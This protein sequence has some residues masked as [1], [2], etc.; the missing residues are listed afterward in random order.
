LVLRTTSHVK[1]IQS[2]TDDAKH[3]CTST[4]GQCPTVTVHGRTDLTFPYIPAHLYYPL[5]ELL[6]NSMRAVVEFHQTDNL[7][8]I[9]V[10]V[11]DHEENEDVSL[12]ISDEGGGIKRSFMPKVWSY[13][14]T[15]V[16]KDVWEENVYADFG[17]NTPMAGFGYGLP[18]S[19]L[20]SRYFGGDLQLLSMEG[21]GTDA[22][23]QIPRIG[24]V[25]E[26]IV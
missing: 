17:R 25:H 24:D 8:P 1:I 5:F 20:Y 23:L 3:V 10:I 11:A 19:R 18:L 6:K 9:R 2:A 4:Y 15:T 7:P 26:P 21:Y 14:F 13:T 16:T 12:K 22:Y